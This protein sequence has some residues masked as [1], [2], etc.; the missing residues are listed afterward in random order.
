LGAIS[1]KTPF[2]DEPGRGDCQELTDKLGLLEKALASKN[3]EGVKEPLRGIHGLVQNRLKRMLL[4]MMGSSDCLALYQFIA[5]FLGKMAPIL[6]DMPSANEASML[7]RLFLNMVHVGLDVFLRQTCRF[8]SEDKAFLFFLMQDVLSGVLYGLPHGN[9]QIVRLAYW[10]EHG[11]FF[12]QVRQACVIVGAS[13]LLKLVID[14]EERI[15][16][17]FDYLGRAC[18]T[19]AS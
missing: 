6:F 4:G 12:Q 3:Y 14:W 7:L 5:T 15:R 17:V 10:L 19:I 11:P 1:I 2:S 13:L 16:L 9:E 18:Q 8:A